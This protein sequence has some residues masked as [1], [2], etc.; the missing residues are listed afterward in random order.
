MKDKFNKVTDVSHF[1]AKAEHPVLNGHIQ[2]KPDMVEGNVTAPDTLPPKYAG[3]I[4]P[5]HSLLQCI[6]LQGQA[7]FRCLCLF[8]HRIEGL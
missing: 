4:Y 2:E 1:S 8:D 5:E 3:S 6:A 7:C